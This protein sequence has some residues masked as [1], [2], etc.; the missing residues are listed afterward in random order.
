[1]ELM[2]LMTMIV[3]ITLTMTMMTMITEDSDDRGET[4]GQALASSLESQLA[5]V[6]SSPAGMH[7]AIH[8]ILYFAVFCILQYFAFLNELH[9]H[10]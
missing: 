7:H 9:T 2:T 4:H 10:L 8:C 5:L 1:M 3:T 6:A